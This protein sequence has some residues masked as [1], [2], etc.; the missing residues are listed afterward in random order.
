MKKIFTLLIFAA[1]LCLAQDIMISNPTEPCGPVRQDYWLSKKADIGQRTRAGAETEKAVPRSKAFTAAAL[2]SYDFGTNVRVNDNPAGTSFESVYSSGGHSMAARGDTVYLAWRSDR[3]PRSTVYFD[4][5]T[6][7]GQTW[8][9]DVRITD[10]DSGAIMPAL[11]VGK[12]GTIYV[13]WTDYRDPSGY[14]HIYFAKSTNGGTSFLPSVRVSAESGEM[15]QQ[16]SSIAVN[17]SGYVFIAYEDWRNYTATAMDIYC[18]RS[19]NGGSSFEP[20]V[21]VD[22]CTDSVDQWLPSIA[23]KDSIVFIS[24]TDFRN[25]SDLYSDIYFARSIDNGESYETNILVNDTIGQVNRSQWSSSIAV[26]EYIYIG[27]ADNRDGNYDVYYAKSNDGGLTFTTPNLNLID[28]AGQP[29]AQGYPSLACDDSGGVYCAWEDIR[30]DYNNARQIYFGF[31]KNYGDSFSFNIH[32]DD[33]PLDDSAWLF[34]PTICVNKAGKVFSAWDDGRNNIGGTKYDIYTTAGTFVNGVAGQPI[35]NNPNPVFR[36]QCYPNPFNNR[37]TVD[38]QIPKTGMVT[39][40]VYNISGQVVSVLVNNIQQGGP[41]SVKWD[42]KDDQG[43]EISSGI[44][45]AR[46]MTDNSTRTNKI[47]LIR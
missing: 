30:N 23:V 20:A 34:T 42:G 29:Y 32:V 8:G 3:N 36:I 18:S 1:N 17:D 33:R 27:F 21:R 43:R 22:D 41:H 25:T 15:P 40:K 6:D 46:L 5:S 12:D 13:S 4:K 31:S 24:W 44:Y 19:T 10:S 28:A 16:K 45:F 14:R 11:A 37:T 38:Y 39:L 9:T 7:G 26:D 47:T 35:E 2:D